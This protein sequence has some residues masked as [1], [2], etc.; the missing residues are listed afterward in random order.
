MR[1]AVRASNVDS[2]LQKKKVKSRTKKKPNH[3]KEEV[4]GQLKKKKSRGNCFTRV[5]RRKSYRWK[6]KP[7]RHNAG[8]A[9]RKKDEGP[10]DQLEKPQF[11]P[12]ENG[13]EK[14]R[15]CQRTVRSDVFWPKK[16]VKRDRGDEKEKPPFSRVAGAS[17]SLPVMERD[18]T[19][20][21]R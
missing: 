8:K 13:R 17:R 19:H 9:N 10:P 11:Q 14:G 16:S 12:V 18:P 21:P 20:K 4:G 3:G 5:R 6:T 1:T 2:G 7:P 15:S